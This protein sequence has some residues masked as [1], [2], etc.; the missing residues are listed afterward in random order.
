[1]RAILRIAKTELQQMFYSPIAWMLLL[2][3][4]IATAVSF[5][6]SIQGFVQES[7]L[8][9]RTYWI[10]ERLFVT[11][12]G[13]R[14]GLWFKIVGY[15]YL[16]VPLLT[17]GVFS[18][19][20]S[21]G[22][23]KLLYSSP[24]SNAHIVLGKFLSMVA[25]A[26]VVV[27]L[28]VVYMVVAGC[29]VENF[30]WKWALTGILGVF[31]LMCTYMA[32]GL[33][34]SSLTR[35]QV[36]SAVGTFLVLYA[37]NWVSGLW[38]Q[39]D[40]VREITY[41][42]GLRDRAGS[43]IYGI[44]GSE[45]LIYFPVVI[46][47]FLTWTI[48]RLHAIRQKERFAV[49]LW[50]NI[51]VIAIVCVIAVVSSRPALM[52]YYDATSIKKNTLTKVSQDIIDKVEGGLTITSYVNVLDPGYG[53]YAYPGFIMKNREAFKQFTRFKPET[54]L[55]VVYYY[56]LPDI[57]NPTPEMDKMAWQQ[58]RKLCEVYEIDSTMLLSRQEVDK[59]TDVKSERY[60]FMR[61]AVRE[62]GQREW[63]RP[64]QNE[65]FMEDVTSIAMLRMVEKSPV[66]GYVTGQ[67]ERSMY[68][69]F[70]YDM[71]YLMT[72]KSMPSAM[73]NIGF[74]VREVTLDERISDDVKILWLSDPRDAFTPEEEDVLREYIDRGGNLVFMGEYLHRDVQNQ[75]LNKYFGVELTPLIVGPD[76]RF[77]GTLPRMDLIAA[78][79]TEI[80]KKKMRQIKGTYTIAHEG[81]AGVEQ[82]ADRGFEMFPVVACDTMSTYW[83]EVETTD[84]VDDTAKFNPQA[85]EISKFFNTVVGLER[86]H[87]GRTQKIMV[88]GDMNCL[89]NG[90]FTITRSVAASNGL[91][92]LGCANWMTDGKLPLDMRRPEFT[93]RVIHLDMGGFSYLQFFIL[94][95]LPI[96]VAGLGVF[97]Y[98]KRRGR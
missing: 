68:G 34:M 25:F 9:G 82:V 39:Y 45:D 69:D 11:G 56:A 85:G 20:L 97:L 75:F 10:S 21:S 76:V 23:I 30:E 87:N 89:T 49:T 51:G 40:L 61:E 38:Q 19:E 17:M 63:I 78:M 59:L 73:C 91:L 37:L 53:S 54:K 42:L 86:E 64:Y 79:P 74:D 52:K 60:R 50:K 62:N 46:A 15:L 8:S 94:W 41:W 66:V 95:F 80:A 13:I 7:A 98:F 35:Y 55:E 32:V 71:G 3:L 22:S 77:K 16:L 84:F 27:L 1:M 72:M 29:L 4:V 44:V 83:T 12:G 5:A 58:A 92:M 90:E 28:M 70:P 2:F 48:I 26:L 14:A 43:F 93:D 36:I 81:A 67:R 88:S 57:A 65:R 6:N 31:F 47:M 24:I 96:A 33:F 18:Q